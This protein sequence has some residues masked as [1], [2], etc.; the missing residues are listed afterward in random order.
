MASV[1]HPAVD[2]MAPLSAVPPYI[3]REARFGA[4]NCAPPLNVRAADFE[5]VVGEV[6]AVCRERA[7]AARD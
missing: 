1:V 3:A 4:H 6:A 7:D 2:R 5:G